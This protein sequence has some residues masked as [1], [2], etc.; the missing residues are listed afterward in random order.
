MEA[1]WR[2]RWLAQPARAVEG[3]EDMSVDDLAR[4]AEGHAHAGQQDQPHDDAHELPHESLA[5]ITLSA[6][7][8]LFAFGL[9]T[10]LVFSVVGLVTMGWALA[11]W[12]REMRHG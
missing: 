10:S 12:I 6:G 4:G 11:T 3:Q 9:L 1:G 7:I 5:P 2:G 8:G